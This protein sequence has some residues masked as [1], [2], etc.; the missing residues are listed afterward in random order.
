MRKEVEQFVRI[1]EE[2][3]NLRFRLPPKKKPKK[4]E[5]SKKITSPKK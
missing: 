3:W 2:Q 1:F 5:Q 4:D